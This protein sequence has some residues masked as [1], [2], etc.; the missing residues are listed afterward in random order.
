[1]FRT[2]IVLLLSVIVTAAPA[3]ADSKVDRSAISDSLTRLA[4]S[5]ASL[6]RTAKHSDD[7]GARKKFAPAAQELSDDLTALAR[8]VGK[9]VPLRAIGKD[10]AAAEKDAGALVE[11]ADEAEEKELRKS[12]RNHASLLQQGMAA[13]RKVVDAAKDGQDSPQAAPRY[14]GRLLNNTNKCSWPGNIRFVVT[15]NGTQV[16]ASRIVF[17]GR[18]QTLVVES[19][20]YAVQVSDTS[21]TTLAS[22]TINA[23]QEGWTLLSG[24]VM[25]KD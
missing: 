4:T 2:A 13:I 16:F 12:L 3:L 8:R 11:L 20:Q 14:T 22:L 21:G 18:D 17:P 25:D 19:G 5:A 24:C 23:N 7:R 15:R 1:M 10:A 6:S 9:G